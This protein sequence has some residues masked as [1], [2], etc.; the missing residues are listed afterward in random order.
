MERRREFGRELRGGAGEVGDL[1][2]SGGRKGSTVSPAGHGGGNRELGSNVGSA[3]EVQGSP[4]GKGRE[5]ST[6][7]F[8]MRPFDEVCASP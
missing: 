7:S 1:Y 6:G 4:W 2:E 3:E 5:G 8:D